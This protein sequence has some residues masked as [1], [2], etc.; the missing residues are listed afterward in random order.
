MCFKNRNLFIIGGK[1]DVIKVYISENYEFID[2]LNNEHILGLTLLRNHLIIS[3]LS[4]I[5]LWAIYN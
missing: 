4:I 1:S 2:I 3:Y 5:L